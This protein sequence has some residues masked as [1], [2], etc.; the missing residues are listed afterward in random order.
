MEEAARDHVVVVG[1]DGSP[2]ARA[3]LRWGAWHAKHVGGTIIAVMAWDVPP[4]YDWEGLDSA[5]VARRTAAGLDAEITEALG[6]EPGVEIRKEVAA[7]HA[8][9]S[10]LD[11][12]DE[13]D[14]TL[15]AVGNRGHGGF[16]P[17]LLGSVSQH[18]VHHAH[19]PVIILREDES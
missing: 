14:A 2:A 17:A 4:I 6:D 7:G 19:C 10:L 11:A 13:F 12:A 8:A 16:A 3:A 18:V 5:D 15:I 1:V 9:T